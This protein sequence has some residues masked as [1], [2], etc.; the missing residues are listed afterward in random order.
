MVPL[1]CSLVT[2]TTLAP[3]R[4]PNPRQDSSLENPH[5]RRPPALLPRHRLE[6]LTQLLQLQPRLLITRP[7]KSPMHTQSPQIRQ[8]ARLYRAVNMVRSDPADLLLLVPRTPQ[9]RA[10]ELQEGQWVRGRDLAGAV[11][12]FGGDEVGGE[13]EVLEGRQLRE[14]VVESVIP[15]LRHILGDAQVR[16]VRTEGFEEGGDEGH[17]EMRAVA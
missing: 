2:T 6:Q 15:Q 13:A 17:G 12:E 3:P 11:E 14:D 8:P 1:P 16:E 10:A 5:S 7:P 9:P 4:N